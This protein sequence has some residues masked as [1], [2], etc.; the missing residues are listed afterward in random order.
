MCRYKSPFLFILLMICLAMPGIASSPSEILGKVSPSEALSKLQ[1]GNTR[2]IRGRSLHINQGRLRRHETSL[3]G[4]HPFASVLTCSDSRVPPEILFD[5]GIGDLFVIRVAGNV[6]DTDEIGTIEYGV[7]HL[8]TSLVVV[9]GHSKCG[10]VTAVT[11][12]AELPGSIGALVDNILPAVKKAKELNPTLQGESLV[13]EVIK[14]NIWQ[15]IEDLLQKS[16]IVS[17]K[18]FCGNTAVIGALYEIDSGKVVWLGPHPDE[19][20]LTA[21]AFKNMAGHAK[22]EP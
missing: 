10:A 3:K 21:D 15:A 14:A 5:Q 22:T 2:Y 8:G 16:T 11:T 13:P 4:Q 12:E 1:K 9:L 20:K 7:D 19:K 17:Q 18:V 6:S